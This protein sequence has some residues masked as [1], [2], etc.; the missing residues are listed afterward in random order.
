M[1]L[2]IHI[3]IQTVLLHSQYFIF[4]YIILLPILGLCQN[5]QNE[6]TFAKP[7]L[8]K[9]TVTSV[10]AGMNYSDFGG[11]MLFDTG[12]ENDT[13]WTIKPWIGYSFGGSILTHY[14][15]NIFSE[16]NLGFRNEKCK[17]EDENISSLRQIFST[18][19]LG[20]NFFN[21][22]GIHA[23]I[24]FVGPFSVKW[25]NN[26]EYFKNG[27]YSAFTAGWLIGL[28]VFINKRFKIGIKQLYNFNSAI[29]LIG[30][31]DSRTVWE[32]KSNSTNITIGYILKSKQF[33][34][35]NQKDFIQCF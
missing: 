16:I 35:R 3:I 14:R 33:I 12:S 11:Y 23:G 8:S 18:I 34:K 1:R 2:N 20:Y 10:F 29:Y 25:K 7:K 24:Y 4:S 5:D 6:Y 22:V 15:N 30:D 32:C 31:S 17:F 9:Y 21:R 27:S 26:S 19:S 13:L 28:E